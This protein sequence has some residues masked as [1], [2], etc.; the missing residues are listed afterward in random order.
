MSSGTPD[1]SKKHDEVC[2]IGGLGRIRGILEI[3]QCMELTKSAAR[4]QLAG[5]FSELDFERMVRTQPGWQRVDELGWLDR[6]GVKATLD[7]SKAGL[8]TLHPV[9]NYLDALPVK[10][11]EY[12]AAGVPVI[13]SHFPVWREIVELHECGLC[14]DPLDP[15]AVAKAIDFLIAHPEEAQRMG[16][17]GQRAV[18]NIYNW[19]IE[20]AKLLA[21]YCSL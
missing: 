12:M 21:F 9:V 18:Q 11:F 5:E 19:R 14:V 20:E 3:V 1:W 13:A 6:I 4:L 2:Y 15:A 17:N 10:M 8:V 7:R 16:G